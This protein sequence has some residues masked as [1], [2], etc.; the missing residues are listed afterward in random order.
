MVVRYQ[1]AK[2]EIYETN[3]P[4]SSAVAFN[5]SNRSRTGHHNDCLVAATD[6]WGTYYPID[7]SSLAA[8][9]DYLNDENK[10]LPQEGETCNFNPPGSDCFSVIQELVKCGGALPT[11]IILIVF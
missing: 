7:P 9:K 11:K 2:K 3:D 6:G 4:I 1:K 10:Y 5:E 8:Q